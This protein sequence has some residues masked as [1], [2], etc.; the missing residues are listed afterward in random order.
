MFNFFFSFRFY[1]RLSRLQALC[2]EG[3][4]HA[5]AQN[6]GVTGRSP[7]PGSPLADTEPLAPLTQSSR[8]CL[9]TSHIPW[10]PVTLSL[11]A[12]PSSLLAP[13]AEFLLWTV[14]ALWTH[15]REPAPGSF[16]LFQPTLSQWTMGEGRKDPILLPP[17]GKSSEVWLML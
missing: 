4:R 15:G 17:V 11:C 5:V 6:A 3:L 9:C 7:A 2:I 12:L 13:H 8:H 16:C 14:G 10:S 1:F